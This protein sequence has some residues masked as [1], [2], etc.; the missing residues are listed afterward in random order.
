M[1]VKTRLKLIAVCIITERYL[2]ILSQGFTKPLVSSTLWE[3]KSHCC[4]ACMFSFSSILAQGL[5]TYLNKTSSDSAAL[6]TNSVRRQKEK[7][8]FS[9][10]EWYTFLSFFHILFDMAGTKH[11]VRVRQSK[12]SSNVYLAMFS[13]LFTF[14]SPF[15]GDWECT[16]CPFTWQLWSN[17]PSL[18]FTALLQCSAGLPFNFT[19][20][21]RMPQYPYEIQLT[22]GNVVRRTNDIFFQKAKFVDKG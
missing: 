20:G 17:S 15:E 22:Y 12:T 10:A 13:E 7:I 18:V 6:F 5:W 3:R 4:A 19:S 8:Q 14:S 2:S 1:R 11:T 21:V 16:M 9:T